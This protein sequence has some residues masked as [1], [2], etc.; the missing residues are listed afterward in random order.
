MM[1]SSVKTGADKSVWVVITAYREERTVGQVVR[2]SL[3]QSP[4]IAVVDDGS[5][6]ETAREALAAGAHVVRHVFNLGQGAALQTGIAFAL[7]EGADLIATMDAD[8]QHDPADIPR[9]IEALKAAGADVALGDRFSG[10]A[11]GISWRRRLILKCAWFLVRLTSGRAISDSQI[12]LRVFTAEA[13]RQL[14]IKQ[15]RMAYASELINQIARLKLKIV[16]IPVS[17]TYTRY[18]IAKGQSGF[19]S[20]NILIDL[21]VGRLVK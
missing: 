1:N 16:E 7:A 14:T 4:H 15:H 17:V 12:G 10:S 13:A 19:N 11:I 21:I 20:I 8:G 5:D 18:S 6:D 9:M 2:E 3:R